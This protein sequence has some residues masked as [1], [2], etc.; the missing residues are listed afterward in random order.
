MEQL[1]AELVRV[2]AERKRLQRQATGKERRGSVLA[3]SV[4]CVWERL[5]SATI[6]LLAQALLMLYCGNIEIV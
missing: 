5:R 2:S 4:L 6:L 1:N 3:E